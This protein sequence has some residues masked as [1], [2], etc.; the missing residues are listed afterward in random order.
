[1]K[2]QFHVYLR[3]HQTRWYTA[4]L[5][6]MPSYAA[7]GPH[8]SQL[9]D[10]LATVV[11]MDVHE[12]ALLSET[13][14]FE[15]LRS[16]TIRLEI[17]AVQHHRLVTVPMRF[18]IAQWQVVDEDDLYEV[19]VPRLDLRFRI[20]GEENIDPWI[21][22]SIRGRFHMSEVKEVLAHRYER[23][24]RISTIDVSFF[25]AD[26]FKKL[27]G[28]REREVRLEDHDAIK[29]L[30]QFGIELVDE[31]KGDRIGRALFRD[32]VVNELATVLSS[33]RDPS[34]LLVGPSGVGK[35]AVVGEL[36]HRVH[37]GQAP[38]RLHETEIWSISASRIIAGAKFLGEW[39]ERAELIVN[40]LSR[41]RHIL[42]LGS[43]LE[44]ITSGNDR[45][46]LNVAQFLL[47]RLQ[48]GELSVIVEATPD[49]VARAEATHGVFVRA[50]QRIPVPALSG[51]EAAEVL[52]RQCRALAKS[53]RIKWTSGVIVEVLDVVGRFGDPGGLPGSG[54]ALLDRIAQSPP[55]RDGQRHVAAGAA[56][57]TFAQ[58]SGF[59]EALVDPKQR[60]NVNELRR[61][62]DDRVI[63][64]PQATELLANVVL[65][66]KAGLNDPEKPLGSYLFMGP[67]GVGKT[68]SALTLAEYLFGDRKRMI[69]FDMSEYGDPG[70]AIRLV[71]GPDG[72]GPLTKRIREQ[73]FSL[74]LFDEIEKADSGV[75]DLLLQILGEGRLTDESGQTV[76]YTH[77]I[78]I[79]TSN[80]GA[81]RR[82][83]I[84]F[85]EPNRRD[86]DRQYLEAAE[87]FFR[88]EMVN[89][90]DHL[91][92][93]Q[94]LGPESLAVI[95]DGLLKRTL[96]R[97]GL[98]RRGISVELDPAVKQIILK[99]GFD[100]RYGAR[101]MKRAIEARVVA[102]L[103]R[104]L[105]TW[106]RKEPCTVKLVVNADQVEV[107]L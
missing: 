101:P 17:M 74:L 84:G 81:G 3:Q 18:T 39:Q 68:E 21:E 48:S 87:K 25:G 44:V 38:D 85:S 63:G 105:A 43:L 34:V 42:Y 96:E 14:Y 83:A 30:S 19:I 22:E 56:V 60:L 67:T 72:Q 24:E 12:R 59:P 71:S 91:V 36:A 62:F 53:H 23:S 70:S 41:Y 88:P 93:F 40:L 10:E 26:R 5:L 75:F 89:R 58:M 28:P 77:C 66:L 104:R 20:Y 99:E 27:R 69:R 37:R 46:G 61:F 52:D 100:P 76:R 55:S 97:E 92:P 11:A 51:R 49:A 29:P 50:L 82:P 2:A 57:R 4:Q 98:S 90:I 31:A 8:P 79:L 9:F 80:L 13:H 32:A 103:A 47:P 45:T 15:G 95:V 35:T 7:Y 1:M 64:Q 86:L 107:V 65:L 33:R 106:T 102:P 54:M 6:T 78:I 94:D 16:R 73:P